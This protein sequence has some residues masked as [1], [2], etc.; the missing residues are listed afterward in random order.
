VVPYDIAPRRLGDPA[1]LV[2]SSKKARETL[3][4]RPK[5]DDLDEIVESAWRWHSNQRF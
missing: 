3:G 5:H 1:V 4:W 2:A